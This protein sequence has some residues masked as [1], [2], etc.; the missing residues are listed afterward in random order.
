[1]YVIVNETPFKNIPFNNYYQTFFFLFG[2]SQNELP[3]TYLEGNG[4]YYVRSN[5]HQ[6]RKHQF[7]SM[8]V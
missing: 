2:K 1:M 6:D 5:L 7:N 8:V 4:N 3:I